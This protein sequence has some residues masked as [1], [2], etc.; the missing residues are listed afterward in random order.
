MAAGP[1]GKTANSQK[2][3]AEV[4]DRQLSPEEAAVFL[5]A[6]EKEIEKILQSKAITFLSPAA[7]RK[8]LE[9]HADRLIGSKFA[10][11]IGWTGAIALPATLCTQLLLEHFV[12]ALNSWMPSPRTV[13]M[14]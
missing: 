2:R 7:T 4:T 3:V 13:W 14:V 5:R 9:E 1:R 10:R 12:S 11:I 8:V 6:K